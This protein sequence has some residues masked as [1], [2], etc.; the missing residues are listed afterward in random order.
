MKGSQLLR[1]EATSIPLILIPWTSIPWTTFWGDAL[2]S[3][4]AALCTLCKDTTGENACC[5]PPKKLELLILRKNKTTLPTFPSNAHC[6]SP[7]QLLPSSVEANLCNRHSMPTVMEP[8][9]IKAWTKSVRAFALESNSR[10][11]DISVIAMILH[12]DTRNACLV[13]VGVWSHW[14]RRIVVCIALIQR[15]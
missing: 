11:C 10:L 8:V 14:P 15:G 1:S 13:D 9:V 5:Y 3:S 2:G 6:C 7:P 12:C 4:P